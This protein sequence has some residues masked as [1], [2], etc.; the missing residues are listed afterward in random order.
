LEAGALKTEPTNSGARISDDRLLGALQHVAKE[1]GVRSLSSGAYEKYRREHPEQGL[2]SSSVIR[3]WKDKWEYALK[4]AGLE[5][6]TTAT[7]LHPQREEVL[8]ALRKAGQA[9]G[10]NLTPRLYNR[11]AQ[12]HGGNFIWPDIDDVLRIFG[13]WE[14]ATRQADIEVIDDLQPGTHWT[15][16]EA[17]RALR[18]VQVINNGPLDKTVYENIR[19]EQANR[20][21]PT[22]DE[23][24]LLLNLSIGSKS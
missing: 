1:L 9:H 21:M 12:E 17:R 10:Y 7:S 11:Y 13:S 16:G 24:C 2:P 3:K 6:V 5:S 14:E 20:P 19:L 23:V 4:D 22:W 18:A 15:I 8:R